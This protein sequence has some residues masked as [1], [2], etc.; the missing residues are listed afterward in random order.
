MRCTIDGKTYN[1]MVKPEIVANLCS[2]KEDVQKRT[3]EWLMSQVRESIGLFNPS[4]SNSSH[5]EEESPACQTECK[6]T[7]E[8]SQL[9][10]S[11]V[12][13]DLDGSSCSSRS[14]FSSEESS[15]QASSSGSNIQDMPTKVWM[16]PEIRLLLDIRFG[17]H[18]EFTSATNHRTLW[19]RVVQ[20][21]SN[22]GVRATVEQCE[23]KFRA[24]K[25]AYIN[26][27]DHNKQTG[28]ERKTWKY[29]EEFND[30]FGSKDVTKPRHLMS[31]M[32]GES[33]DTGV[34]KEKKDTKKPKSRK[35]KASEATSDWLENYNSNSRKQK[36][37]G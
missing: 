16:E 9:L 19:R 2:S 33:V 35:R 23:N 34:T 20:E 27:V 1:V 6:P 18:D 31:S 28:N 8:N 4:S 29:M 25:R 21:L 36:K 37:K 26:I 7:I 32:T 5:K 13:P 10:E 3:S 12:E 15:A 30:K 17:M 14:L 11:E 24:L 22:H